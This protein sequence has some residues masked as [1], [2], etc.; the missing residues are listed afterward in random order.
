MMDVVTETHTPRPEPGMAAPLILTLLLLP[1]GL[2][3]ALIQG[4]KARREGQTQ[5]P[6][7]VGFAI[8]AVLDLLAWYL[9]TR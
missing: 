2:V 5:Q 6:I 4:Q 8:G 1:L 9:L 7:W 3:Y